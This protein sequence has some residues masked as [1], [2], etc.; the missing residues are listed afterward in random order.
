MGLYYFRFWKKNL[1]TIFH[2]TWK[3]Q[4]IQVSVL[5]KK[6]VLELSH[7]HSWTFCCSCALLAELN[8]WDRHHMAHRKIKYLSSSLWQKCWI[9]NVS[10]G[11]QIRQWNKIE[12]R[13]TPDTPTVHRIELLFNPWLTPWDLHVKVK[14]TPFYNVIGLQVFLSSSYL[15]CVSQ[16]HTIEGQHFLHLS[17][18]T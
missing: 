12:N 4:R 11:G 13:R 5:I 18:L 1:R 9:P 17:P 15:P 6:K 2:E 10:N 16:V 3:S 8:I 14:K 7:V